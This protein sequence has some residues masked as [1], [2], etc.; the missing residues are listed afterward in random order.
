[1]FHFALSFLALQAAAAIPAGPR[2]DHAIA[3]AG[4]RLARD[5]LFK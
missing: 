3:T 5:M 4:H 2:A 1:M